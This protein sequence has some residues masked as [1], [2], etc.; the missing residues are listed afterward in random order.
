MALLETSTATTCTSAPDAQQLDVVD[1]DDLAA[2]G[3]DQLL[4]EEGGRE[5]Q[6][7][8]PQLALAE[9]VAGHAQQ[10]ARL[11][12]AGDRRPTPRRRVLPRRL[13]ARAV[14]RG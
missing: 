1:A 2:V 4:V 5:L 6:L 10:R 7:V 8:R 12:E 13:T 14:T 11:L 3:V 9:L